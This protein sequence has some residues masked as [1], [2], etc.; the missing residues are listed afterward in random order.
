MVLCPVRIS[1]P[2]EVELASPPESWVSFPCEDLPCHRHSREKGN[3]PLFAECKL[4]SR[5]VVSA[6]CESP[7]F[8]QMAWPLS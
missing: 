6:Q 2:V 4:R 7:Q 8:R 3:L 1:K 5:T